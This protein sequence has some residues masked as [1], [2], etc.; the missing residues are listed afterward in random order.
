MEKTSHV[1]M[2]SYSL[3]CLHDDLVVV[4]G[5]SDHAFTFESLLFC[6]DA[7]G[8]LNPEPIRFT[9]HNCV[10]AYAADF[11]GSGKKSLVFVNQQQSSAYG[12]IPVYVYLGSKDGF[13]PD[14][15]LEF[16]GHSAGTTLSVDFNDDGWPDL[17]ILQNA[18]DQPFLK[19]KG[20]L[21]WGGPDGFSLDRKS[22]IDAPLAWGGHCADLNKD[23]YLDM[24]IPFYDNYN[25]KAWEKQRKNEL[26]APILPRPR[27]RDGTR[28]RR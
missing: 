7:E 11:D 24:D 14:N 13:T 20:D 12:H 21:Y 27:I 22:E 17:L 19:P 2:L 8:N 16:P 1:V 10:E 28:S 9:T 23:G 15:R 5:R 18:E 4:Q 25:G 26:G 3:H 6:S